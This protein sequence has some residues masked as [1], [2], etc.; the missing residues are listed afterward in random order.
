[1]TKGAKRAGEVEPKKI[2]LLS[3]EKMNCEPIVNLCRWKSEYYFSIFYGSKQLLDFPHTRGG[4][5]RDGPAISEALINVSDLSGVR[6]L[7]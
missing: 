4:E 7:K 5:S 3:T 6:L 2:W 1:M